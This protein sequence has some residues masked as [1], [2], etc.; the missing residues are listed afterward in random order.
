MGDAYDYYKQTYIGLTDADFAEI[1]KRVMANQSSI[2]YQEESNLLQKYMLERHKLPSS[3]NTVQE[4][5]E[6][7][8][9]V[10]AKQKEKDMA[11]YKYKNAEGKEVYGK[12]LVIDGMQWVM[13]EVGSGAIHAISAKDA[14]EVLPYTVAIVF[15]ADGGGASRPYH[16]AAKEGDVDVGDLLYLEGTS[17]L[18]KVMDVNTKYKSAVKPLKGWKLSGRPLAVVDVETD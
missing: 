4:M 16:Y 1:E 18:A 13:K 14:Q 11:I 6:A 10:F 2:R 9:G 5:K 8:R 7:T 12:R 17:G 3:S 15:L